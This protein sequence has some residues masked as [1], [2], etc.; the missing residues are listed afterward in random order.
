MVV[1]GGGLSGTTT[2]VEGAGAGCST[3]V[4]R[5]LHAAN[6]TEINATANIG[7]IAC[8]LVVVLKRE[9]PTET[10]RSASPGSC[11]GPQKPKCVVVVVLLLLSGPTT[12][13]LTVFSS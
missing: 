11:H 4:L 2:A 5:K 12:V 9:R 10:R 1:V 6:R 7:F 8:S 13:G 3:V